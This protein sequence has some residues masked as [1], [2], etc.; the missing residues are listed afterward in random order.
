MVFILLI[1]DRKGNVSLGQTCD[2]VCCLSPHGNLD[3]FDSF[4]PSLL[5]ALRVLQLT[6][7]G[8]GIK[9]GFGCDLSLKLLYLGFLY[10]Q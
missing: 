10:V 8:Q 7:A 5:S 4:P 9:Q 2:I 1:T 6:R 3:P